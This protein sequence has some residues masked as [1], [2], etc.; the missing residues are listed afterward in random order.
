MRDPEHFFDALL[1]I[2]Y[3]A[4]GAEIK[5]HGNLLLT[6]VTNSIFFHHNYFNSLFIS[7]AT[8]TKRNCDFMSAYFWFWT[9]LFAHLEKVDCV[10]NISHRRSVHISCLGGTYTQIWELFRCFSYEPL[11]L[12][13][14]PPTAYDISLLIKTNLRHK[15]V[16]KNEAIDL[17]NLSICEKNNSLLKNT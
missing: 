3:N 9:A 10:N 7:N 8:G 1:N 17:T 14:K 2:L 11:I 13:E 12:L 5:E 15:V 16:N 4:E 6:S